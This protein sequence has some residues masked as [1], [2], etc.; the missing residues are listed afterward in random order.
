MKHD[1]PAGILVMEDR[2]MGTPI[3]DAFS[4][5]GFPVFTVHTNTGIN[6]SA[7]DS[8]NPSLSQLN[9]CFPSFEAFLTSPGKTEHRLVSGA[10]AVQ[11]PFFRPQF[12]ALG[13][14]P[15]KSVV[16]LSSFD[17]I[18][19]ELPP[20]Q[21]GAYPPPLVL[22]ALG[23]VEES[24]PSS[25][26][27]A[28]KAASVLL[29]DL[30]YR[31]AVVHG[32]LKVGGAGLEALVHEVRRKGALFLRFSTNRP[33]FSRDH[34]GGFIVQCPDEAGRMQLTLAPS[35]IVVDETLAADPSVSYTAAVLKTKPGPDGF[36]PSDNI[37]RHG[38]GTNRRGIL[39]ILPGTDP[40]GRDSLEDDISVAMLELRALTISSKRDP[41]K[42]A[43][44]DSGLCARC[45]TCFRACPHG[46]VSIKE[47]VEIVPLACFACGICEAACPGRAITLKA[48]DQSGSEPR[49]LQALADSEIPEI[50]P[51]DVVALGCRRSAERALALCRHLGGKL[52]ENLVFIPVECAGNVSRDMLMEVFLSDAAGVLVLA[53]HQG[54]CH[55]E[56]GNLEA[57]ARVE[58][59][60]GFLREMGLDPARLRFR[61]LAANSGAELG[62]LVRDFNDSLKDT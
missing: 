28:L 25:T 14:E 6:V 18:L 22:F 3:A 17:R 29:D 4:R 42:A 30:D 60:R 20:A 55:S 1:K 37:H 13:L 36:L 26:R 53:C 38:M 31:V 2:I 61:T 32:N 46:A 56:R 15:G 40:L 57:Q 19:R 10:V 54:N 35:Y 39:G 49:G 58:G 52:P 34:D 43:F 11:A 12:E 8:E 5:K 24:L 27:E 23:L 62:A 45:L 16:S 44:I 21:K 50:S 33:V 47:R 9:G 41:E 51:G 7:V 48:S 59:V